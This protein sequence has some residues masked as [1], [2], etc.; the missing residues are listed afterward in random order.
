MNITPAQ[1]EALNA[2]LVAYVRD[3]PQSWR[4]GMIEFYIYSIQPERNSMTFSFWLKHRQPF[5]DCC[6]V[7]GDTGRFMLFLCGTLRELGLEYV[8]PNQPVQISKAMDI[9]AGLGQGPEDMASGSRPAHSTSFPVAQPLPVFAQARQLSS[10]NSGTPPMDQPEHN[11][12]E[13]PASGLLDNNLLDKVHAATSRWVDVKAGDI[14]QVWRPD[15]QKF[16]TSDLQEMQQEAPQGQVS[17]GLP[18][19]H[20]GA[21]AAY[22]AM[23]APTESHQPSGSPQPTRLPPTAAHETGSD[24]GGHFSP[25]GRT[26]GSMEQ[27]HTGDIARSASA[28]LPR[29][30]S[31]PQLVHSG[32]S[33]LQV[34]GLS[35]AGRQHSSARNSLSG[36]VGAFGGGD[37]AAAPKTGKPIELSHSVPSFGGLKLKPL[38]QRQ[39]HTRDKPLALQRQRELEAKAKRAAGRG[40]G[41]QLA[42]G[43]DTAS[44]GSAG[45]AGEQAGAAAGRPSAVSRAGDSDGDTVASLPPAAATRSK[46]WAALRRGQGQIG[47]ANAPEAFAHAL[48]SMDAEYTPQAAAAAAAAAAGEHAVAPAIGRTDSMSSAGVA[49]SI[50]SSGVLHVSKSHDNLSSLRNF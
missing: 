9:G 43:R 39:K 4:S 28:Q 17:L 13:E 41:K 37:A 47:S 27:S 18:A 46:S 40:G 30:A 48:A 34:T 50:K 29:T 12:H 24:G 16:K 38:N 32:S 44:V 15:Q 23:F 1:V 5:Q 11:A 19:L 42:W 49:G 31:G 3:R 22:T 26:S 25:L 20:G 2:A 45:A 14:A 8:L 36:S 7:F 33:L 10:Q 6:A 21:P 35:T